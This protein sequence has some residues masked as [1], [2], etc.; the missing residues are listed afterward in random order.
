MS[1]L[2]DYKNQAKYSMCTS[3][4]IAET[5]EQQPDQW[6]YANGDTVAWDKTAPS[7]F[8]WYD[9]SSSQLKSICLS[10]KNQPSSS[11]SFKIAG[12]EFADG[13][14]LT[15]EPSSV[16]VN[17][18][19]Y[20]SDKFSIGDFQCP[21]PT[22]KTFADLIFVVDSSYSLNEE[23]WN[24]QISFVRSV[25]KSFTLGSDATYTSLISFS[26]EHNGCSKYWQEFCEDKRE[27]DWRRGESADSLFGIY[28]D[29][30]SFDPKWRPKSDCRFDKYCSHVSDSH[31]FKLHYDLM[32]AD[33]LGKTVERTMYENTCQAYGLEEAMRALDRSKRKNM[34]P[35]PQAI[36]VVVTDGF[37]MCPNR[38]RKAAKKLI[39]EYKALVV[40]VGVGLECRY[41]E[42]FLKSIAS[43]LA[44]EDAPAYVSV[45]DYAS[46]KNIID[47]IVAPVC[48][49]F[50]SSGC[51]NDCHGF[52][53]C[54]QC[55]CP[56]C[57]T[58]KDSCYESTCTARDGTASG[59]V[60]KEDP[61]GDEEDACK[62]WQ[63]DGT[64]SKEDRCSYTEV[65]CG[66]EKL[67]KCQS[68]KCHKVGGC[69]AVVNNDNMCDRGNKCQV[70]NCT[71][72]GEDG[73]ALV[74]EVKCEDPRPCIESKC[75]PTT[76]ECL[77][78][79]TC[80]QYANACYDVVC[81]MNGCNFTEKQKPQVDACV[82]DV[83]CVNSSGWRTVKKTAESCR[84]EAE[85]EGK[86][87][88]CMLYECK[89]DEGGCVSTVNKN[90][91]ADICTAE[92]EANCKKNLKHNAT[93]CQ[94]VHCE[95]IEGEAT[96][97][98][99]SVKC[100]SDGPCTEG[101]CDQETGT[102][103]SREVENPF[104]HT[105][106][107][108]RCFE[109]FCNSVTNQ[110][111]KRATEE[112]ENCVS[113]ECAVRQCDSERGCVADSSICQSTN[114]TRASCRDKKC[115]REEVSCQSSL[116]QVSECIEEQGGCVQHDREPTEVCKEKPATCYDVKCNPVTDACE[117]SE[118]K[119]PSSDPC[120]LY[121]CDMETGVWTE[122]SKCDDGILCT[123][124]R[125]SY[126]GTCTNLPT[127][128]PDLSMVGF[129]C[130]APA[131]NER[132]GC[133]RKLYANAYV[134]ICGNCIRE[135]VT[136]DPNATVTSSEEDNC[137][138]G[139]GNNSLQPA[140]TTAAVVGIVLV[141]IVVGIALTVSGVFGT[142][143]LV[144]RA[145]G[146]QNQSA[147]SNPLY[148]TD[149]QEMTNP[150]FLGDQ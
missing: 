51:S 5:M 1:E 16:K 112:N 29:K 60:L 96:C 20:E 34:N 52:C 114:C 71:G 47:N 116:C 66:A 79:D 36:V 73:C 43:K 108:N 57:D 54:G 28:G 13:R 130:F 126:D 7:G 121:T 88:V 98:Y 128:C 135:D 2:Y 22:C 142:K 109:V 85:K 61:C 100:E 49:G 82:E 17:S 83:T 10:T 26:A 113:D 101:Y 145:Q 24:Q 38:T 144:K 45:D 6:W 65:T 146:A 80:K 74:S 95:T 123:D 18:I 50:S 9:R 150:A 77:Y 138:D 67:K 64:K 141:A 76:G 94:T 68:V 75:D 44:G 8:T 72:E 59:C 120:M 23:E 3:K 140:L 90:C 127:D 87:T 63:C 110:Y 78:T 48:D 92:F 143:E 62:V 122:A 99:E 149:E 147:H 132:R 14:K 104:G 115:V 134:D 70:W 46:I 129:T 105:L 118:K 25:Q 19:D 117:Y 107:G 91:E 35:P 55:F 106:D 32:G 111:E 125:C 136:A 33:A 40:E 27:P 4:C 58:P 86:Q 30:N 39:E 42:D 37:D 119:P 139:M 12:I 53:G 69:G 93:E 131:C 97:V 11:N 31:R 148:E 133:Y 15:V 102:C 81:G 21:V 41:D 124:D 89:A 103:K 56:D 84:E 137:M